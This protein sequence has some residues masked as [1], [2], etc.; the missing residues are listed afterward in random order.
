MERR[1]KQGSVSKKLASASFHSETKAAG[2][3]GTF[4]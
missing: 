2:H 1:D 4:L 3:H